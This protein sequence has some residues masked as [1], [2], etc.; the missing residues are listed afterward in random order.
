ML[1]EKLDQ[2]NMPCLGIHASVPPEVR[3][4]GPEY[5]E[6]KLQSYF[7]NLGRKLNMLNVSMVGIG[8]PMSRTLS[9]GFSRTMA[10]EQMIHSLTIACQEMPQQQILLESLNAME[11]N[12]INSITTA[13][14]LISRVNAPN[15]GLVLDLYHFILCDDE[16]NMLTDDCIRKIAYLHVADPFERRYPSEQTDEILEK[17]LKD[18]VGLVSCDAIALEAISAPGNPDLAEGMAYLHTKLK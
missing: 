14:Q 7:H 11:T 5:S 4:N 2:M 15:V 9:T 17:L 18:V 10:D 12:Y 3:F 6:E 13:Y 8:S 1:A 16:L